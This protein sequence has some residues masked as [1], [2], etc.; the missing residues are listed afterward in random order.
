MVRARRC[1]PGRR[2]I[3][4]ERDVVERPERD[5]RGAL[6][7]GVPM[8]PASYVANQAVIEYY[9]RAGRAA[10]AVA[11]AEGRRPLGSRLAAGHHALVYHRAVA[12]HHAVEGRPSRAAVDPVGGG[13][14]PQPR[15]L[16][17]RG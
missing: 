8:T 1:R 10:R 12:G 17:V 16:I 4:V 13:H 6:S 9:Q 3:G 2:V 11:A 5:L 15:R 14:L 7:R